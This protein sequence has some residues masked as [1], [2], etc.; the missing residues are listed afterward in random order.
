MKYVIS[1]IL[2]LIPLLLALTLT[3]FVLMRLIPGDPVTIMLGHGAP[4]DVVAA[5][6]ARLGL[7][8]PFFTQYFIFLKNL[9]TGDLGVSLSTGNPVAEE[10]AR[11]YGYTFVLALG[12]TAVAAVLGMAV[13][14]I[15]AVNRDT[16]VDNAI[17]TISMLAIST[18]SFFLALILM[19]FFTLK[20]GWFPSMGF[21]SWKSAVL[22]VMTLGLNAVGLVARTTRSSMLD[23]LDQDY[24]RTSR[25]VGIPKKIIIYSHAL[26]NALIP[27]ATVLGLRFGG[28]LVGATI[29]ET[30]FSIPGIGRFM[31]DGVLKRDYP[32]VQS[33]ILA[34]AATFVIVNTMVDL[35]Y[36]LID[37]RVKYD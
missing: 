36:A 21:T 26:K 24:I 22:P 12:G 5:E 9:L 3:V 30:V 15:A 32:V 16:V 37:P 20:L 34:F 28:L 2:Q 6:R 27:V 8:Q 33:T 18:P 7:D 11:R 10:L 1:R 19:L 31:V 13:G 23:V 14:I 17:I 35:I 4:A 29:V 25:A